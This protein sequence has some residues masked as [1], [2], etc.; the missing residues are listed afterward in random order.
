MEPYIVSV[1]SVLLG[2]ASSRFASEKPK[3]ILPTVGIASLLAL[4]AVCL[5]FLAHWV[6]GL[7]SSSGLE[8]QWVERYKENDKTRY[9]IATFEHNLVDNFLLFSGNAYDLD[10]GFVGEWHAIEARY[11]S[12]QYDYLFEGSS[13]NPDLDKRGHREGAGSIYFPDGNRGI[14]IFL[15]FREDRE[16]RD[17]QLYRILSKA[18]AQESLEKPEAFIRRL[19]TDPTYFN[20]V[21]GLDGQ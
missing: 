15:S 17:F 10:Q 5:T 16:P 18:A 2:Y 14:G 1:I 9:A 7:H 4:G 6:M 19:N 3:G 11:D 20:K 13:N 12:G 21:I 8:G